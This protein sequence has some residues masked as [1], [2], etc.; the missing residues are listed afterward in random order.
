[1]KEYPEFIIYQPLK[2]IDLYLDDDP[3]GL[4]K[5]LCELIQ[6]FNDSSDIKQD[7]ADVLDRAYYWAKRI[8][9]EKY[10]AISGFKNRLFNLISIHHSHCSPVSFSNATSMGLA[11]TYAMLKLQDELSPSVEEFLPELFSLFKYDDIVNL[12]ICI[13]DFLHKHGDK[14]YHTDLRPKINYYRNTELKEATDD[15]SIDGIERLLKIYNDKKVQTSVLSCI[16]KAY[17]EIVG[18]IEQ[19]DLPF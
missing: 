17:T 13:N 11:I 10:P 4:N 18:E 12:Q 19:Y 2:D 1:M 16:K 9:L 7:P 15:F 14:K 3:D 5:V 6:D 8:C